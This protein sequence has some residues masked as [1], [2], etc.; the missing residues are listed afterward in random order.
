M[1]KNLSSVSF[2]TIFGFFTNISPR[3]GLI[4]EVYCREEETFQIKTPFRLGG[5]LFQILILHAPNKGEFFL[6][7]PTSSFGNLPAF[8]FRNAKHIATYEGR[9]ES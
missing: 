3:R 8:F 1:K 2:S 5:C 9:V 7:A 4:V 6:Q